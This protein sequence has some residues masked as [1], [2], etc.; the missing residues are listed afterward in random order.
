MISDLG[1]SAT[2]LAQAQSATQAPR[3]DPSGMPQQQG[4]FAGNSKGGFGAFLNAIAGQE[5]GGNYSAQNKSSGA[6]GKYQIM[7]SNIMGTGK[8]W[9]YEALG[10]DV[11]IGEFLGSPKIQEAIA[12]Y[13]LQ[14]YYQK[15]GAAGA[16]VAWYA[17]PGTVSGYMKNPGKYMN[18]QG[19]YPS[20]A[21]YV[22]QVLAR[23]GG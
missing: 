16:A 9:D 1:T 4:S 11:N 2:A 19:A 10:R 14:S 5:S 7:P 17:G 20:I 3:F 8:G 22:Q 18:P 15:Y 6:M 23:M 12:Q 21:A 13:K